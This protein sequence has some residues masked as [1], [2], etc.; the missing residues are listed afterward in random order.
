MKTE[1]KLTRKELKTLFYPGRKMMLIACLIPMREPQPRTVKEQRS[2]GY[3]MET[4]AG[5]RSEMRHETGQTILGIHEGN[6][7]T[8]VKIVDENG[9][10]QVHYKLLADNEEFPKPQPVDF[11]VV[12][13]GSIYLLRPNTE[14]AQLWIDEHIPEDAQR[15]GMAVVIEHR[16][17]RDICKGIEADGLTGESK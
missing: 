8:E 14:A 10:V 7:Y 4:A 6:G 15:F 11:T 5:K 16:Y 9:E 13:Q 12:N 17:I 3:V 1:T 2:F